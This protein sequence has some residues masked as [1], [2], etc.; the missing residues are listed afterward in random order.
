MKLHTLVL[1]LAMGLCAGAWAAGNIDTVSGEA[2]IIN[3]DG[4]PRT[5]N[6]GERVI[7]GETVATGAAGEVILLTDDSGVL[8][9]RPLSRVKIEKYQISG[10]DK[11]TVSLHLLRGALRSITGWIGKTSPR[12]Y[13]VITPT[14]TVGIRGT[15]HETV[16]AEEGA[17]AGTYDR[18][19][20]GETALETA[21]GSVFLQ[22]GQTGRAGARDQL[23]QLLAQAPAALYPA[24]ASDAAIDT[25]K[26]EAQG[27]QATRLRARQ[28]QNQRS[29]GTSSQGNPAISAQCT[30]NSPAQ[31]ALDDFLRA[32]E[33]GNVALIQQRLDPALIGYSVLINDI[34]RD[35]NVQK[36]TQIRVLDRQMQ[37][38]P[39]V[40]VIDFAWEK[41]FIDLANF[42][43]QLE[44][45]RASV[46]ISG[47][48]AGQNGQWRISGF[49]G[50]NPFRTSAGTP[51]GLQVS[52]ASI[53]YAGVPGT[54]LV[55]GSA[56]VS[57]N[58]PYTLFVTN[59]CAPAGNGS[60]NFTHPAFPPATILSPPAV[61]T[62][63][64]APGAATPV[65]ALGVGSAT[66]SGTPGSVVNLST[67]IPASGSAGPSS[68]SA[69]LTCNTTV[70]ISPSA[71]CTASPSILPVSFTVTDSAR[72][73][74]PM[75][76]V[77]VAGSNG[78]RETL[79]LMATTPGT[80]VLMSLPV[81][82]GAAANPGNGR[83]E[84]AG[85][86]TFTV[87]YRSAGGVQVTRTFTVTP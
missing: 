14:A 58:K 2:S 80:F 4:Q 66:F 11:D 84:F 16:I 12:N 83:L 51:P 30:P 38:G 48:G 13:Q 64:I 68:V 40:S 39:D 47:L 20:S 9:V 72:A 37:C 85:P 44:R 28:E 60:C 74:Q 78:D 3:R 86:T 55:T 69:N 10:T 41:R 5:A 82:K 71:A 62:S 49:N 65:T 6:K 24:R 34:M 73:G 87:A 35:A 56:S 21:S 59:N 81:Q 63:C 23:P 15:D 53:S 17:E 18:V 27:N 57:A 31:R 61:V 79:Q 25:L 75:A 67:V 77:Q 43:P 50:D 52:P 19:Y 76:P 7:E 36:Q 45:G 26:Q 70:T 29:G 22:S 8:A 33:Q 42:Q 46:L 32:Y 1:A 54:C